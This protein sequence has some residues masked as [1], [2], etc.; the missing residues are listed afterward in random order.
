MGVNNYVT[1]DMTTSLPDSLNLLSLNTNSSYEV[2][3]NIAQVGFN[4]IKQR[5]GLV[6]GV[7]FKWNNYKFRNENT[8]LEADSTPLYFYEA[9][10]NA[11]M[12]KLTTW[13]LTVPL[14]LEIQI[15]TGGSDIYLSGGV[16]G[17][18]KL[19]SHTKIKTNSKEKIKDKRDFYTTAFDYR[20]MARIGYGDFG[21][22][23]AYSLMPL[24]E[25]DKGP[26]LYPIALGVSFNF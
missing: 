2:N 1:P 23:G 15:P 7:G 24:F 16:E 8:V 18:L 19:S 25:K 9:D 11:K 22:Y 12:S 4:L 14:L 6:T 5:V 26:E 17:G 3:L 20:L 13:Y 10:N 21:F